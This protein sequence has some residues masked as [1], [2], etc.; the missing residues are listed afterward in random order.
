M[1]AVKNAGVGAVEW[2][3]EKER[4]EVRQRRREVEKKK[5]I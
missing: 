2:G 3:V 1:G 4:G 5:E